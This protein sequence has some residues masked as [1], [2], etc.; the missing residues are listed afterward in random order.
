MKE[1]QKAN[2]GAEDLA[3]FFNEEESEKKPFRTMVEF[4]D[5]SF[6]CRDLTRI[7]RTVEASSR[8]VTGI[9]CKL[10]LQLGAFPY[11]EVFQ[12][13]DIETRDRA[14][15]L[16]KMKMEDLRMVFEVAKPMESEEMAEEE[17]EE[18]VDEQEDLFDG[19]QDLIKK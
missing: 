9:S 4:E 13:P 10:T 8:F 6:N 18:E 7:R 2:K 16:L 19:L 15:E 14:Y 11:E 5:I 17:P 1:G 12:Y 3:G